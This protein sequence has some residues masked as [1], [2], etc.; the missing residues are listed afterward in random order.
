MF[1]V[2]LALLGGCNGIDVGFDDPDVVAP[3]AVWVE[4]T[5]GSGPA[6]AVDVLFV[7]DGTGSMAEEQASLAAASAAFVTILSG[8]A[9]AWQLG[10]TS[11]DLSDEGM[12]MGDPWVITPEA[13]A[14][15]D[16]LAEA[17]TVGT[18]HVPPSSGLDS[19]TL[20]LRDASGDNRGFR[21]EGA[22]LHIIFVSDDDDQSGAVLGADPVGAFTS[23]LANEAAR[24]GQPARAS[25]VVGPAPL[26]CEGA[27][28]SARAGGRYLE[29]VER[30]GGSAT[31]VCDVDFTS[32]AAALGALAVDWPTRYVLQ[33]IPME[34]TLSVTLNGERTTAFALDEAVIAFSE[35]PGP[36]VEVRARYRLAEE[37]S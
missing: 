24:S 18:A 3:D 12:L 34:G 32:V 21:R 4:E 25:A 36:D 30:T 16:A 29:V 5:L 7:V 14:P 9:L 35:A 19:A 8:Q 20:A 15:A 28:G 1:V 22:A 27:T 13:S 10:A 2:F 37:S 11:S 31:S 33:A 23:L 26:G 6:P 17:L